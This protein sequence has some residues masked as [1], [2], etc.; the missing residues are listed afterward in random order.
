[1]TTYIAVFGDMRVEPVLDLIEYVIPFHREKTWK[2][3]GERSASKWWRTGTGIKKKVQVFSNI[4]QS[5]ECISRTEVGVGLYQVLIEITHE[6]WSGDVTEESIATE[7]GVLLE[8]AG[9][10]VEI[11]PNGD[12]NDRLRFG[13]FLQNSST[14]LGSLMKGLTS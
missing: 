12:P 5:A 13:E 4:P 7:I 10:D 6:S 3:S 8:A 14:L 9:Y 2:K 11:W 1:M